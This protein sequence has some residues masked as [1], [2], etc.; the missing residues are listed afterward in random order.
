[1]V[2]VKEMHVVGESKHQLSLVQTYRIALNS[3]GSVSLPVTHL[4]CSRAD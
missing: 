1:M 4:C 3:C 2:P